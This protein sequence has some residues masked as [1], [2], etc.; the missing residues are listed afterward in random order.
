M[1]LA[2]LIRERP[3][4]DLGLFAWQ[5]VYSNTPPASNI[6]N[7]SGE[8]C[9]AVAVDCQFNTFPEPNHGV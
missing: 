7:V 5:F 4:Y 1:G 2:Q 8:D 6:C 3:P 9:K